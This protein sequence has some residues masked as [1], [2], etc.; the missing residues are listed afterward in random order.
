L[1]H[2][3]SLANLQPKSHPIGHK[4]K[5]GKYWQVKI[6][7]NQ[8]EYVHRLLAEQLLERPLKPNERVYFKEGVPKEAYKNP[9]PADIEI[10]PVVPTEGK[11]P[12][13]RSVVIKRVLRLRASLAEA[14]D[15]L[16]AH[17]AF[18][19]RPPDDISDL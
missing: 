9:L 5:N 13:R 4:Q 8:W 12:G 14:E 1:T 2:P 18:Y 10:R 11:P 17:N 6:G 15:D 7:P 3:N 16:A 19:G